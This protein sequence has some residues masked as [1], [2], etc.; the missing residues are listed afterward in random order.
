VLRYLV[1]KGVDLNSVVPQEK[2]TP[3]Q[4]AAEKGNRRIINLLL[5]LG[6]DIDGPKGE[7]GLIIHYALMSGNESIVR[8]VLD[9]GA[10]IDDSNI[11]WGSIIRA[12]KHELTGLLPLLLEKGADV[13]PPS[14]SH[15][16]AAEAFENA[17]K[18][19]FKMLM[20]HGA[21]FGNDFHILEHTIERRPLKDLKE[22]LEYGVDPN[23]PGGWKQ[24]ATVS[25]S[26]NVNRTL[27][28]AYE[29]ESNLHWN[30]ANELGE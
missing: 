29:G 6:A 16:P 30:L 25:H 12:I 10:V 2:C 23:I 28:E 27:I 3:L 21:A 7:N 19:I 1:E 8:H 18:K 5:E 22:L 17:P 14:P 24:A 4:H 9:K 13:N 11:A 15:S 20:D 26:N